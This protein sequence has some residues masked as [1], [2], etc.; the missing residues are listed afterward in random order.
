MVLIKSKQK[1]VIARGQDYRYGFHEDPVEMPQKHADLITRSSNFYEVKNKGIKL[2]DL[3]NMTMSGLRLF[4]KNHNLK[5]KDNDKSE[6]IEEI[7][8]ELKQRGEL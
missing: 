5:C 1:D 4:V 7:K 2:P 3:D 6:L 8:E